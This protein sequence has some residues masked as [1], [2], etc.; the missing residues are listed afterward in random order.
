MV[1]VQLRE[2]QFGTFVGL[3]DLEDIKVLMEC[4]SQEDMYEMYKDEAGVTPSNARRFWKFLK[5]KK[6]QAVIIM[7]KENQAD[8]KPARKS[9]ES[10]KDVFENWLRENELGIYVQF[11]MIDD[12]NTYEFQSSEEIYKYF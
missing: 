8:K 10:D 5:E 11:E 2:N 4:A 1:Q 9:S 3:V 12:V 7:G 6:K